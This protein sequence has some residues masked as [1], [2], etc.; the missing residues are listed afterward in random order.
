MY[1]SRLIIIA[2]SLMLITGYAF[3][4]K[5]KT[6]CHNDQTISISKNAVNAHMAHG[7]TMGSCPPAPVYQAVVMIRC[8]NNNGAL[9]VSGVSTST[10]SGIADPIT[11][12]E[13]CADA[14]ADMMNMG[15]QL[16][17]VS[18]GLTIGETEYL[19]I[20]QTRRSVAPK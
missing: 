16:E 10:N 15:Y 13:P 19:F 12:R 18:T 2:A 20:G 17:Q 11:P 7:D 14:V 8:L 1:L 4:G 5:K 3:A 6:V 9:V